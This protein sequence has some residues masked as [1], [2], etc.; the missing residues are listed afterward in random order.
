MVFFA[1]KQSRAPA[2]IIFCKKSADCQPQEGMLMDMDCDEAQKE[3][4]NVRAGSEK[5]LSARLIIIIWAVK[6]LSFKNL[7]GERFAV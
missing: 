1:K 5:A 7:E 6:I 3:V 4:N 2:Q